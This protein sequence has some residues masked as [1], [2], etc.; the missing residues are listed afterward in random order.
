MPNFTQA[1]HIVNEDK[2]SELHSFVYRSN[3]FIQC[4]QI[5]YSII[6]SFK[7]EFI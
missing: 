5:D 3:L 1:K 2:R 6:Y 4:I 7:N